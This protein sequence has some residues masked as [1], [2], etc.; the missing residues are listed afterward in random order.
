V[1]ESAYAQPMGVA[2]N[3]WARVMAEQIAGFGFWE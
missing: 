2:A 1:N 3:D